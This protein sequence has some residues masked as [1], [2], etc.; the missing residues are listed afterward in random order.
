MA[1]AADV[2]LHLTGLLPADFLR[3]N[4]SFAVQVCRCR[5]L[6]VVVAV[7][8]AVRSRLTCHIVGLDQ[9]LLAGLLEVARLVI[10][11]V[12]LSVL[13]SGRLLLVVDRSADVDTG[14]RETFSVGGVFFEVRELAFMEQIVAHGLIFVD[15]R[16]LTL[17]L[18]PRAQL[19]DLSL[20]N[21]GT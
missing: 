12:F 20:A 6:E 17:R 3:L 13:V 9:I 1:D 4:L 7:V 10:I 8:L 19:L 11:R 14:V 5:R 2:T 15:V 16:D 21:G 18:D